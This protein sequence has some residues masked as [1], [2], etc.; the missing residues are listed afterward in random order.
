MKLFLF[1]NFLT[2]QAFAYPVIVE[3]KNN[4]M[5]VFENKKKSVLTR[6][7]ALRSPFFVTTEKTDEIKIRFGDNDFIKVL[8]NAK[9]QIP[10]VF[11]SE[12]KPY[13]VILL[14]GL[15]RLTNDRAS[16]HSVRQ[17]IKSAFFDL[18]QPA[19]SDILIFV[20]MAKPAVEIKIIKGAW[21]LEF[22][23]Y[24]KKL[25]L[26][27]GQ[28]I[29]F[30]GVLN[31]EKSSLKYDFL[32]DGR[33]VPKGKLLDVKKFD[34]T[35][36]LNQEKFL[37]KEAARL[38]KLEQKKIEEA[39]RKKK[40]WED[41]FLCKNPFAQVNQCAWKNE[42]DTCIRQRC[43]VSG[44]WGDRTERPESDKCTDQFLIGKCDY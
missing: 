25:T 21:D 3:W 14:E 33:K 34:I 15:I 9:I 4:P 7:E 19:E 5:I 22:F 28:Q 43:N 23:S 6:N 2:F 27:A 10:E 36:Y 37:I 18:K 30:E 26:K 16:H 31:D 35:G 32:L 1:V 13:D 39:R 20:D 38:K 11:E 17:N 8:A 24:E 29:R 40:E 12:I 41:S 44:Q 42:G